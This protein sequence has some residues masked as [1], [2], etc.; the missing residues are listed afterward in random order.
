MKPEIKP[1][2]TE[3]GEGEFVNWKDGETKI[4]V[5]TN[6]GQYKK[7][8]KLQNGDKVIKD[9][10]Y[11]DV[12]KV[13]GQEFPIGEKI[14]DTNSVNF[15]KSIKPF[16]IGKDLK[17]AVCLKISRKGQNKETTYFIENVDKIKIS[18][19]KAIQEDNFVI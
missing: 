8:V 16:L 7:E 5:I 12:L 1:I 6:F 3:F 11:A 14:I 19:K 18:G 4:V 17:S 15:I 9:A 10:L 13:D 2:D